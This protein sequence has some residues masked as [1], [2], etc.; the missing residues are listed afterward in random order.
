MNQKEIIDIGYYQ[1]IVV[2][3][4]MTF[5]INGMT[6]ESLDDRQA[7]LIDSLDKTFP[8][9]EYWSLNRQD[10]IDTVKT[11]IGVDC[12]NEPLPNY[13]PAD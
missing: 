1:R 13:H 10:I 5:T 11:Q 9:F 7:K 8:S 2:F 4:D 12:N 6:K 3:R